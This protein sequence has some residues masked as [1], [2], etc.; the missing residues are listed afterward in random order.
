LN[1]V[2]L[3]A[4]KKSIILKKYFPFKISHLKTNEMKLVN[5]NKKYW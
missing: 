4:W 5:I 2:N 1:R 3:K